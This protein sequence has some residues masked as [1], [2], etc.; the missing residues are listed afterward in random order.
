MPVNQTIIRTILYQVEERG[1]T[2]I[3][4]DPEREYLKEFYQEEQRRH[5]L[6]SQRRPLSLLVNR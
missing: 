5:H 1:E 4:F 3:V 6:K 2:A